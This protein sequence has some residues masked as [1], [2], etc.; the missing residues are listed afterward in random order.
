MFQ[1][2]VIGYQR[3]M[4]LRVPALSWRLD[5]V[6][7]ET[8]TPDSRANR[9][10]GLRCQ[11]DVNHGIL[12]RPGSAHSLTIYSYL[13]QVSRYNITWP[14][15]RTM[16]TSSRMHPCTPLAPRQDRQYDIVVNGSAWVGKF[17]AWQFPVMQAADL[18]IWEACPL[19]DLRGRCQKTALLAP[20][21]APAPLL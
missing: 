19:P 17:A 2:S 16:A 21:L 14:T 9:E 10:R 8:A 6:R 18:E 5:V 4:P 12:C 7:Q 11:T 20:A 3:C 13:F 1:G 15:H